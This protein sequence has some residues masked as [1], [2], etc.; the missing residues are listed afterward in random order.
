MIKFLLVPCHILAFSFHECLYFYL[1]L[2]CISYAVESQLG[3]WHL[4]NENGS[5][6]S[7]APIN[8]QFFYCSCSNK[9]VLFL[10]LNRNVSIPMVCLSETDSTERCTRI[11][12]CI[13][14]LQFHISRFQIRAIKQTKF[15]VSR[16]HFI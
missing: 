4:A 8:F 16:K 1:I 6:V 11:T 15:N 7:L 2:R 14:C 9:N 12:K 5:N 10:C 3:H 13:F